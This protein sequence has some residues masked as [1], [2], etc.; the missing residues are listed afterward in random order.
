MN[1]KWATLGMAAM[2]GLAARMQQR[3]HFNESNLPTAVNRA[4]TNRRGAES[5]SGPPRPIS[6][7]ADTHHRCSVEHH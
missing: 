7:R 1:R 3:R 6:F 2:L 5:R 4:P